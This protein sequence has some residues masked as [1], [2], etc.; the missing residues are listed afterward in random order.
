M[1]GCQVSWLLLQWPVKAQSFVFE[2]RALVVTPPAPHTVWVW[3][4]WRSTVGSDWINHSFSAV[5]FGDVSLW[6]IT[7]HW[8]TPGSPGIISEVR[9]QVM[10]FLCKDIMTEWWMVCS[11]SAPPQGPQTGLSFHTHSGLFCKTQSGER[12]Y[13]LCGTKSS[14]FFKAQL[15]LRII[16]GGRGFLE[17]GPGG[18]S[19]KWEMV[20]CH[21]QSKRS[22]RGNMNYNYRFHSGHFCSQ[23]SVTACRR[24]TP[25]VLRLGTESTLT[26]ILQNKSSLHSLWFQF[27]SHR[28]K[29]CN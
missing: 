25:T 12:R 15:R 11:S 29:W 27:F 17:R 28:P 13:I 7:S 4:F 20:S 5:D 2:Q 16:D 8:L 1:L 24:E 19:T 14:Y 22:Q 6:G 18:Y 26:W 9:C 10:W 3:V 23:H 21:Y